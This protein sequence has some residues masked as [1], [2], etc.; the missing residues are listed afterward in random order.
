MN[1]REAFEGKLKCKDILNRVCF[2]ENSN[3]Y[4]DLFSDDPVKPFNLGVLNGAWWTWQEQQK[5]IDE[6]DFVIQELIKIKEQQLKKLQENLIRLADQ[7]KR[8]DAAL[9]IVDQAKD[10]YYGFS[11]EGGDTDN[12]A[13]H[14]ENA[15]RGGQ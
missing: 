1:S 4:I 11:S 13:S 5:R 8:I 15:L 6:K 7:E 10:G 3:S 2:D 9:S 12:L 14:L